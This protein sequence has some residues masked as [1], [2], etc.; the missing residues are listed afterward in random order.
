LPSARSTLSDT[1]LAV[2]A[3]AR[4]GAPNDS[5]REIEAP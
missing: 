1:A 2:S 4:T 5:D 3:K